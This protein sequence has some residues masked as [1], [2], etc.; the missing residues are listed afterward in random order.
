MFIK[1]IT[2]INKMQKRAQV[3]VF[4]ILGIVLLII[5]GLI[6]YLRNIGIGVDTN[7][8]IENQKE[9]IQ[10]H[11]ESC[12][13]QEATPILNVIALQGGTLVPTK[14][15]LYNGYQINY[16]CYNQINTELCINRVLT[17]KSME[18]EISRQLKT[19]IQ[20]CLDIKQFETSNTKI[21]TGNLDVSLT[22]GE[23]N[24]LFV[25]D[26]PITILKDNTRDSITRFTK[27]INNPL[28]LL[29]NTA[30]TIIESE[31]SFGDFDQLPYMI[32]YKNVIIE[33]DR[34]FPDK[35]YKIKTINDPYTFQFAIEGEP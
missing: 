30:V 19:N 31:S 1:F 14:S 15:R 18:D 8:F 35:V 33:K 16:L 13:E 5:L 3:T 6:L 29:F 34:P 2:N 21:S 20:S 7:V 17:L 9:A 24:I 23:K 11:V 26:Y 25:V 28:G 27:T 32:I 10:D 4:V 22:I 12:I